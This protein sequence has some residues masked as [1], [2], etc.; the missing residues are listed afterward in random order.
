MQWRF[1]RSHWPLAVQTWS[2][3]VPRQNQ[4]NFYCHPWQKATVFGS[5]YPN[6]YVWKLLFPLFSIYHAIMVLAREKN[7]KSKRKTSKKLDKAWTTVS[8]IPDALAE[9]LIPLM[10][11]WKIYLT[12]AIILKIIVLHQNDINFIQHYIQQYLQ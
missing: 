12:K 5:C 10:K 1:S 2:T 8:H 7:K 4:H 11:T 6:P 3:P 9:I